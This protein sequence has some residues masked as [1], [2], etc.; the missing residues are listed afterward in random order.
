MITRS[1]T[2]TPEFYKSLSSLF[3]SIA[4]SDKNIVPKEKL[5][6]IELV[7]KYWSAKKEDFDSKAYIYSELK[8]LI[9]SKLN[10]EIAFDNFKSY[11]QENQ[12]IFSFDLRK[13]IMNSAYEIA[14]A[15][16]K[17]NKSELLLL[18]KL[19]MLLFEN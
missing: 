16:A 10:K 9:Q 11:F 7:E 8:S 3:Y 15:F 4:A 14:N 2:Y 5:K 13:N 17:R 1:T 6:I 18:S 12:S 19:H